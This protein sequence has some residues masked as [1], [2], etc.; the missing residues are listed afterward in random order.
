MRIAFA[1]RLT[2]H[3]LTALALL[4]A[5]A[6][7][8]ADKTPASATIGDAEP[9]ALAGCKPRLLDGAPAIALDFTRPLDPK[10][11]FGKLL[12]A[13]EDGKDIAARWVVGDN[14]RVL[15]LPFAKPDHEYAVKL[16]ATLASRAGDKLGAAADCTAKSEAMPP[17]FYFA[18]RGIVLPAGE[19]GGLPVVTINTPEVDVQFLRIAPAQLPRFL[20]MVAGR[21]EREN[22]ADEGDVAEED[23]DGYRY[24]GWQNRTRYKGLVSYYELDELK[25]MATSVYLGRFATDK[26]ENRRNTSFL[27]VERIKELREPGIYLAV[28]NVPGRFGYDY[29]VTYFYV[30]DIG[31]HARRHD[32]Q[33][34][35]FATSLKSGEAIRNVDVQLLDA[36]GKTL[37]RASTDRDGHA[38][39]NGGAAAATV[40]LAKRGEEHS[41][42]ALR[43][44][45]LDL[46]EFD[47]GGHLP[48]RSKLF[49]Y[50]GRDLYRPGEGFDVSVLARD[51]DGRAVDAATPV[52]LRLKRP[53]GEKVSETLLRP[54]TARA[55][56]AP[57]AQPA[58]AGQAAPAITLGTGYYR[59]R[60]TLP[61]DAATGRW[62]IEARTDP[63]AKRADAQ[64]SFQ[65]EEFL[66]ERLKLDLQSDAESLAPGA[67]FT[68]DVKGDYRYGAPAAG[69]RLLGSLLVERR[70]VALPQQWPG[71]VFGD[72]DDDAA[73]KRADLPEQ[74]LD[75]AGKGSVEVPLE[76]DE[77]KSPMT[78]RA[79]FSLLETGGRPVVRSI[80][81][82][83][84]PADAMVGIRP[85]FD[86]DIAAEGQLAEF[87]L[88]RVGRDG[89]AV[90]GKPVAIRL[91]R[92]NRRW[93]W[94]FSDSGGWQS[95]YDTD[96]E[97]IET[98]SLAIDKRAKLALPVTWG[99]YRL[100]V[101]DPDNGLVA[102]YRFYAGWGALDAD[103]AG[104][105]PDRVQLRL[106]GAPYADGGK[107]RVTVTPPH[108]GEALVTVEGDRVLWSSRVKVKAS[109]TT[110][111]VPVSADWKRH[112]LYLTVV[113]FRPGSQG[114]RVTPARA[115]GLTWLPLAREDRRLKVTLDAPAKVLPETRVN[116]KVKLAG[117]DGKP[118]G[119]GVVNAA[120]PAGSADGKPADAAAPA[121]TRPVIVTVSAVDTGI[122]DITRYR[123]PDPFD[124]FFGKH[125][126][127][128]DQLDFYG[129]LIEKLDGNLAKQRFGGDSGM[130]DTRSPPQKVKLVD[131]FSGP[132]AIDANGEASIPLDLPDFNGTLRLMVV[133]S[134]ADRFGSAEAEMTVAAPIVAELNLPRFISPG[135]TAGIGLDLTNLSGA[136]QD[137]TLRLAADGPV[138]INGGERTL[139]LANGER[140]TLRFTAEATDAAGLAA[141]RLTLNAG[142]LAL[143]RE[144]ALDVRPTT[145]LQ[146]DVKRLRIDAG[147][148]VKLDTAALD[149]LWAGS[150]TVGLSASARPPI[151]ARSAVRGLLRYP[152]GC[153]EQTV[154]SA[155]PNVFIDEP[156]ARAWALD[157]ASL[158][159]RRKRLDSAFARLGG[160]QQA[161]GGFGLWGSSSPYEEWLS[162]YAVAFLLDA[163]EAGFAPPEA[164]LKRALDLQLTEFQQ[165]PGRQVK[166][167]ADLRTDD[168]GR[169]VWT[170]RELLRNAHERFEIAVYQGYVLA[171]EARAPLATLRRLHDEA[172]GNARS[173]LPLVQLG[174]A[175]RLMG[176][177][178]RAR[179]A[180]DE[181]V[182]KPWGLVPASSGW[183]DDWL[184]HYGSRERDVALAYALLVRHKAL[185]DKRDNLIAE[186]VDAFDARHSLGDWHSTQ[187]QAAIFLAARAA[188]YGPA[189][190]KTEPRPEIRLDIEADGATDS[191]VTRGTLSRGW[192]G[193]VAR[194]G[195][196][197]KNRGDT[198]VW[199]EVAT[200]G[201]PL[202]APV[203][204]EPRIAIERSWWT[205]DGKPVAGREFRTGEV[206]LVRLRVTAKQPVAQ[207]LVVDRIPA[208]MEIE[209]LNLVDGQGAAAYT[210]EGVPIAGALANEAI[211]HVEYRDDR[212]VAAARLGYDKLDLYYVL[213]VVTPGRYAAPASYAEDMY[214]PALRGIGK[215]EAEVTVVDPARR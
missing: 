18:S 150:A 182:A 195:V 38:V 27:P 186:L 85:L 211:R 166:L 52:T 47:T 130:R 174:L 8:G 103:D 158:D 65:V 143:K 12:H 48:A 173:P 79:S 19:S 4:G 178:A 108:D 7:C 177:E 137:V 70:R 68:V 15:W 122:L 34:D 188:G 41:L 134:G 24:G 204:A 46:S 114:E 199:L 215:P 193:P 206:V 207:G 64:W 84:W 9:F 189:D 208:G 59:Q 152:Y 119:A 1:R 13:S 61:P 183:W 133:A 115:I 88:A 111:D 118:Y 139:K 160:M 28:M 11:D 56:A 140:Q 116:L 176:D 80:E 181:A 202:K 141:L 93:Y 197:V 135:D 99:R 17:S 117:A 97:L 63:G 169:P 53:D 210:V 20:D 14:P 165:Q 154:S 66:P 94:R 39:F 192:T 23:D 112:D 120:K 69:N 37:A 100:E 149:G 156:T 2:R 162:T 95:G 105:R 50:A 125:R 109:G 106:E 5:L 180:L 159:E 170:D 78:V 185:P 129:K 77:R 54:A 213:R 144:A 128:A 184:T 10:Q 31:L 205:V 58:Q 36:N 146:R 92:E 124:F 171:R 71:F 164:M 60:I 155:Y 44:P 6:G 187:E 57:A 110:I 104:N 86:R 157:P 168:R 72:F 81:R 126:Y 163:R 172:R 51:A 90:A 161:R 203:I 21:R 67:A 82:A 98:R 148:S 194:R 29:Q 198:P 136:P 147:A 45:A 196:T 151:D 132:V 91:V 42:L 32:E 49:V 43:D 209:N 167:P 22:T 16:D 75:S 153:L 87:E 89:K 190:D 62:L 113:A 25:D 212:F 40:L 175:L 33:T 201:F 131:L 107:A 127:D 102:R 145:P 74:E 123:T 55:A 138:R 121:A 35:V 83:W 30:T 191:S 3:A 76:L 96:E 26:R 200:E 73:R 214:R 179:V 101:A 142:K